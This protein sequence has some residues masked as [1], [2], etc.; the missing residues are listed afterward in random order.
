MQENHEVLTFT[1][2]AL[3]I[4]LHDKLQ[5]CANK[6]VLQDTDIFPFNFTRL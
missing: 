2:H 3:S 4:F 6:L 1:L 5:K